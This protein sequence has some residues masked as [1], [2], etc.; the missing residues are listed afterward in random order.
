MNQDAILSRMEPVITFST[1]QSL[2]NNKDLVASATLPIAKFVDLFRPDSYI[3]SQSKRWAPVW[4]PCTFTH[5]SREAEYVSHMSA[6]VVDYDTGSHSDLLLHVDRLTTLGHHFLTH[7]SYGYD[8]QDAGKCRFIF[9]LDS[10]IP[11]GT[12]WR[13]SDAIWPRLAT[14]FGFEADA[15]KACKDASRAF[16]MPIKKSRAAP[17]YFHYNPGED[18]DTNAVLGDI[19]SVPITKYDYHRPYISKQDPTAEVN[20]SDLY[21]R[22]SCQ[23]G[24]TKK[25]HGIAVWKVLRAEPTPAGE[26]HETLRLFTHALARVAEPE[27]PSEKLIAIMYPWLDALG[28]RADEGEALRALEGAR[29]KI[30]T[31]DARAAY[32]FTENLRRFDGR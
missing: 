7:S 30:P 28:S 22:I 23:F 27:E 20:L 15:D 18:L 6:F 24:N 9:F 32:E 3:V 26:R 8:G 25:P 19:L 5:P 29:E 4:M 17:V 16:F 10:P 31:W 1:A 13:W 11:T 21:L 2:N 14:H 12:Q